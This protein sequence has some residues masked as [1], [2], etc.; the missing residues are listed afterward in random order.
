MKF[1]GKRAFNGRVVV[2]FRQ[3][4]KVCVPGQ[5]SSSGVVSRCCDGGGHVQMEAS[6]ARSALVLIP[7]VRGGGWGE[8]AKF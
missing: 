1:A 7:L 2:S 3:Y 8:G 4:A 5:T 6:T